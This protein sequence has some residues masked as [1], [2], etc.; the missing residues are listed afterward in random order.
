MG[1][2]GSNQPG[3]AANVELPGCRGFA[4]QAVVLAWICWLIAPGCVRPVEREFSPADA[5]RKLSSKHQTQIAEGLMRMF[6]TP[7][8]PRLQTT[9]S[10]DT[11]NVE[12]ENSKQRPAWV[13]LVSSEQLARG[14]AIYHKRCVGCHGVGGDGN[15]TAAAYLRPR[16]RDYRKGIFKFTA[17]PYG[18]KP[19]RQDLV[20]VIRRGAKGTSMPAFPWMPNDELEDLIEYV[21]L[22]SQRGEVE[23]AVAQAAEFDY[24]P[25]EAIEIDE[26]TGALAE[27]RASWE[28]AADQ[29][30]QPVTAEPPYNDESVRIGRA[31]FLKENCNKCHGDALEGQIAWL[32]PEFLARQKSLPEDQRELINYDAWGE[33]APA[34]DLTARMLHGGRRSLDIYRRIHTGINGT[35]M[36]AFGELFAAE[37]DKIWHLVHYVRH[38]LDGGDPRVP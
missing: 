7:D 17:T 10:P 31:L 16:P 19:T 15:G 11:E 4:R 23:A 8:A 28:T 36:P 1:N 9:E 35:P 37:P 32:N 2:A 5:S 18:A 30:V 27:V 3:T 24:E 29:A 21:I 34:A 22:L 26:F 14:A 38:V 12:G 6:G 20:R 33:P 25:Q 13:P